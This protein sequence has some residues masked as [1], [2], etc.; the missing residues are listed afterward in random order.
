MNNRDKKINNKVRK[1]NS[2]VTLSKKEKVFYN[3]K[4]NKKLMKLICKKNKIH[5]KLNQ[6]QK[7]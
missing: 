3:G 5:R 2:L 7:R 1:N 6:K 4:I